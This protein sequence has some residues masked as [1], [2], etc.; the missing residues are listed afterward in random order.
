VSA[1]TDRVDAAK[2]TGGNLFRQTVFALWKAA[3][4]I[5]SEDAGTQF[6]VKRLAWATRLRFG[7]VSA[8]ESW[9]TRVIPQVLENATIQA[10]PELATDSDVQFVVNSLVNDWIEKG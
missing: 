2:N 3:A 6:H 5:A 4:D 10:A 9:A 1:Y 7:G 8:A